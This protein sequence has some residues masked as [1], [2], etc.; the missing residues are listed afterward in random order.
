[1]SMKSGF[2][3]A[4]NGRGYNYRNQVNKKNGIRKEKEK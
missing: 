1:M 4:D 3:H 2:N